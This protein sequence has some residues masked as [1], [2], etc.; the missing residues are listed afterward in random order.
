MRKR[1]HSHRSCLLTIG[2][3]LLFMAGVPVGLILL[4]M[5]G[6]YI[7]AAAVIVMT[8]AVIV[9]TLTHGLFST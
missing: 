8:A 4:S 9:L 5:I 6:P 1:T 7:L 3:C 2:G